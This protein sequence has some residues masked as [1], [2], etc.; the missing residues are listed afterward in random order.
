[1]QIPEHTI[2]QKQADSGQSLANILAWES[3]LGNRNIHEHPIRAL[4]SGV[5]SASIPCSPYLS[6]LKWKG[7]PK[8]ALQK[9]SFDKPHSWVS[10]LSETWV[11]TWSTPNWLSLASFSRCFI[12]AWEGKKESSQGPRA[13]RLHRTTGLKAW[14]ARSHSW[15]WVFLPCLASPCLKALATRARKKR[16]GLN[17]DSLTEIWSQWLPQR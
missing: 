12:R 15:R 9:P 3:N 7:W 13:C 14:L 11:Q 8:M 17:V 4:S 6:A 2:V 10:F 5:I 1:M 16:P